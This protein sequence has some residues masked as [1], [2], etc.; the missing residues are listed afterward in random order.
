MFLFELL[1]S[2]LSS[3]DNGFVV[4]SFVM[5]SAKFISTQVKVNGD[6]FPEIPHLSKSFVV[7]SYS[8]AAFLMGHFLRKRLLLMKVS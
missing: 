1:L 6:Y 8:E 7:M 5:I 2:L 3:H 4:L